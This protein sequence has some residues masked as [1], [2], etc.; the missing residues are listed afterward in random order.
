MAACYAF[1]WLILI[2]CTLPWAS[3]HPCITCTQTSPRCPPP[4]PNHVCLLVVDEDGVGAAGLQAA[5]LLPLQVVL[6]GV[7]GEAPAA[8]ERK[9]AVIISVATPRKPI[10]G[11]TQASSTCTPP[12][13][14]APVTTCKWKALTFHSP[15]P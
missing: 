13:K 2:S 8:N 4:S 5:L 11:S 15:T 6:T 7:G 14:S 10:S 12:L 3:Q 9:S 1:C